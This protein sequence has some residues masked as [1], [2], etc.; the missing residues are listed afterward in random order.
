P[1]DELVVREPVRPRAGVDP[2][3]PQAAERTLAVLPVAV[4]VD[5]RVL[6]LLLRVLVVRALETPVALGLL[7]H[8][9]TLLARAD[10]SLHAGHYDLP[11]SLLTRPVSAFATGRSLLNPRFFFAG[12]GPRLWLWFA[13]RRRS[14]PL[15]V[16]LNF[17]FAPEL[18]FCFGI[19]LHPRVLRRS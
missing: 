8:L 9:A 10:R 12:L 13:V 3:D 14:F 2:H 16:T 1:G 19:F 5:E 11:R 6:D 18:V 7:E 4:G 17:F 15:P